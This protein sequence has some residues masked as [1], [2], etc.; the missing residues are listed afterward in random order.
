MMM[1]RC[2]ALF[3]PLV[4]IACSGGG[5]EA[6]NNAQGDASAVVEEA[7]DNLQ[8][9]PVNSVVPIGN[10]ASALPAAT[11]VTSIPVAFQG[12]WGMVPNDC[13]PKMDYAAKGLMTVTADRLRFY[14]SRATI[15]D[16]K[17]A[18]TVLTAT[19]SFSGEG[20]T[21]QQQ[22]R[23]TLLDDGKTLVRDG[24]G[25]G[26]EGGPFRYSKCPEVAA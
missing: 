1:I 24:T 3:L 22:A 18:G 15:S 10:T 21:W 6:G 25:E 8:D 19:L 20:Q 26:M 23:M 12:R 11:P 14:E 5:G 2:G 13:D 17:Q 7:P 4:L 16:A 9:D